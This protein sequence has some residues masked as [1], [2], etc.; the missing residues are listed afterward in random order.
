MEDPFPGVKGSFWVAI[1]MS[2]S[3]F[4]ALF[5]SWGGGL[6]LNPGRA[7][8]FEDIVSATG[9]R[10]VFLGDSTTALRGFFLVDFISALG[11]NSSLGDQ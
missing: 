3:L 5:Q 2:G 1:S 6:F 7:F 11:G 8:F 10:R 4:G 9:G